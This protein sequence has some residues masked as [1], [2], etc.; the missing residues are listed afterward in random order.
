MTSDLKFMQPSILCSSTANVMQQG[1]SR[2][3]YSLHGE[4]LPFIC[5]S[6]ILY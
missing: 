4:P 1:N 6:L 2:F 5:S 3:D